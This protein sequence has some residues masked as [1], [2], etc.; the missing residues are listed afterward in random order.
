M[1]EL[2]LVET[3]TPATVRREVTDIQTL[4]A[5]GKVKMEI[6]NSELNEKVPA[7]KVWDVVANVRIVERDA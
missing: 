7:G 5:R 2:E 1:A 3:I 6:G 4:S